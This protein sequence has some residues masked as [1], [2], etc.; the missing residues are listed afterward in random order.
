MYGNESIYNLVTVDYSGRTASPKR[1]VDIKNNR[2]SQELTGSTFG[3]H[4][5]TRLPGAGRI[6]KEE[7][8]YF[9][10]NPA[11]SRGISPL[12]KR[13]Q[14]AEMRTKGSFKYKDQQKEQVPDRRERPVM[15]IKT[16]KNFI[17]ANAVEAILQVPKVVE[18]V[19]L[20]Y[21]KKEDF[22][23]VPSYLA[24][25]KE[26]IARENEMIDKY[27]K[28]QM[29]QIDAEPDTYDEISDEE[30]MALISALK[31]K[32]DDANRKYQK[33]THLTELDT[34]GQIRRKEQ[35]EAQMTELENDIE[36]L[37]R[38]GPLLIK[39]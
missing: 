17:T 14:Q 36:K 8:K 22:G 20:N 26:E 30:R 35:M 39:R 38:R 32:W 34:A 13:E 16:T 7:G 37:S 10:L 5:T 23:K 31:D 3:C 9:G 2:K 21:M 19:E 27:V 1:K 24:E 15:G 28:E 12:L 25:V 6:I 18:N 11:L 33:G 4:G 29:G